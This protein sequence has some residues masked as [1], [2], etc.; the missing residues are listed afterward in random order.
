MCPKIKFTHKL[1]IE[2]CKVELVLHVQMARGPY[3]LSEQNLLKMT[4]ML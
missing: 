4:L 2:T 3:G 1:Y